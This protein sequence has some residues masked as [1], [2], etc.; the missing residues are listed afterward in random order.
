MVR[1]WQ[2]FFYGGRYVAT[3][4]HNPDFCKLAEAH[5]LHELFAIGVTELC[6]HGRTTEA[7]SIDTE[8]A[9]LLDTALGLDLDD[10]VRARMCAAATVLYMLSGRDRGRELFFEA[11]T[12][13]RRS[14]DRDVIGEVLRRAHLG[15]SHPDDLDARARVAEELGEV[16]GDDPD[17]RWEAALLRFGVALAR[18]EQPALDDSL[19][20]M[21]DN[22]ELIAAGNRQVGTNFT[23]AAYA[24]VMGDLERAEGH[25]SD[26]F[27]LSA[28]RYTSSWATMIYGGLLLGIRSDQ[29]RLGELLP[30]FQSLEPD[31]SF[32]A[33]V[34]ALITTLAAHAGEVDLA[35]Q[36][37]D[38][39]KASQFDSLPRDYTWTSACILLAAAVEFFDDTEAAAMLTEQLL[40]YSGQMSY[41]SMGTQGP[42]DYAL[43][44]LALVLGDTDAAHRHDS[45]AADLK[46]RLGLPDDDQR[47]RVTLPT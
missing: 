19:E 32:A 11:V 45:I 28:S 5:G 29:G 18:A 46:R 2:E 14:G 38:D 30:T 35:R 8:I 44:Q 34:N 26:A 36:I 22:I 1:Q 47:W 7:G 24:H 37:L 40:P 4:M 33:A 31:V 41:N 6:S 20:T 27:Q 10:A 15:L 39:L 17:L 42:I 43:A 23:E 13:A 21:R 3:P 25:A 12:L 16:A 9:E